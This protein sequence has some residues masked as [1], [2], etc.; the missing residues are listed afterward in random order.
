MAEAKVT[1]NV[2]INKQ[3]TLHT[4]KLIREV[5]DDTDSTEEVVLALDVAIGII[6]TMGKE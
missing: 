6:E 1:V 5:A 3:L 4:L 2:A